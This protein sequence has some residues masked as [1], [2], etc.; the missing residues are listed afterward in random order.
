M[1]KNMRVNKVLL[2]MLLGAACLPALAEDMHDADEVVT[3][4]RRIATSGLGPTLAFNIEA[5]RSGMIMS[6]DSQIKNA[7][8]SAEVVT[9]TMQNL[10]DGN[11]ISRKSSS[12]SYRD[13]AGRTRQEFHGPNGELHLVKIHDSVDNVSYTLNVANK[14]ATKVVRNVAA[15]RES[16]A[17]TRADIAKMIKEGKHAPSRMQHGADSDPAGPAREEIRIRVASSLNGRPLPQ[18][19]MHER[20]GPIIA[21]AFNDAKWAAK[22][23][24]R[25]LGSKEIEGVKA[26]GKMRSYEIPA[27]AMGNRNPIVVSDEAWTSD[28][29]GVTLYTRHSDPRSGERIY[30]MDKLKRE[31]PAASLFTVPSDYTVKEIKLP[32]PRA[33]SLR[34]PQE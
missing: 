18:L 17:K 24:T 16:M 23:T 34:K 4:E 29:L 27:G 25:D 2:A 31:E 26:E 33:I 1:N 9:E 32:L 21:G 10:A 19:M 14:T 11:Q 5:M 28:E 6:I 22:A 12:M 3:V 15:E 30:R 8:Y 7:P 20:V 13:R